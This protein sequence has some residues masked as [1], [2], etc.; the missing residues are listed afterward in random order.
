MFPTFTK[1][2]EH[3]PTAESGRDPY[4]L[5]TYYQTA[6]SWERGKYFE[7]PLFVLKNFACQHSGQNKFLNAQLVCLFGAFSN[8][9]LCQNT[10]EHLSHILHFRN[11]AFFN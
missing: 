3:C 1:D 7:K 4:H 9:R 2:E 8:G 6:G 10:S 11:L 5:T